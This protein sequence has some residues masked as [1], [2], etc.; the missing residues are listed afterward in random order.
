MPTVWLKFAPGWMGCPWQSMLAAARCKVLSPQAIL[1]RLTGAM[2][3]A[4]GLLAGGVQD[5]PA[6]QQTIRQTIDW[7][8]NLLSEREQTLFRR[9]GVFVGGCTLDAIE[10]VCGKL[11][12]ESQPRLRSAPH[13]SALDSAIALV[14]QSLLR[15]VEGLDGEPRFFM[16]ETLREYAFECLIA[17]NE[18]E[19]MRQSACSLLSPSG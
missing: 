3:G 9:L 16:S 13:I 6:R 7:S 2:G 11:K 14:D 10:D 15:Q 18:L 17:R 1:A 8:Y 19:M 5:L 4:L 12:A